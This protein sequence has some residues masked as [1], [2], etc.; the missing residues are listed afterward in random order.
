MW[1]LRGAL[2]IFWKGKDKSLS[3]RALNAERCIMYMAGSCGIPG[4]Q[5]WLAIGTLNRSIIVPVDSFPETFDTQPSG[6]YVDRG[7]WIQF[8]NKVIK[9]DKAA[10]PSPQLRLRS[11]KHY[12]DL[13]IYLLVYY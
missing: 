4:S 13:I 6:I 8:T 11:F 9:P 5:K 12:L 2:L 10:L 1:G 3:P 7:V